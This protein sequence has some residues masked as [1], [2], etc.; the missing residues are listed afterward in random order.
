MKYTYGKTAC[1]ATDAANVRGV[2]VSTADG[3]CFRVYDN[4]GD[5]IDYQLL[6]DDLEVT[7]DSSALASFYQNDDIAVLDHSPAVL[8]L[9]PAIYIA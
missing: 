2:L 4:S 6:H 5:F 7:I 9:K 8:G 3:Y 1:E